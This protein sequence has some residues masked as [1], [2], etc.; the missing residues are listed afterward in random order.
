MILIFAKRIIT[1]NHSKN[2]NKLIDYHT[3][4]LLGSKNEPKKYFY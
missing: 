2:L 3:R 1:F 4:I